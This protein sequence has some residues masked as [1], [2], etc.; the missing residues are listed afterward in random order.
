MIYER[1]R[2]PFIETILTLASLVV[3]N[4]EY[5]LRSLGLVTTPAHVCS[6]HNGGG[7]GTT[8]LDSFHRRQRKHIK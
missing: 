5:E 1:H 8:R 3:P 6:A 7:D 4:T 2:A